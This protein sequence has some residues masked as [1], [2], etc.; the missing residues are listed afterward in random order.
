MCVMQW[1]YFHSKVRWIYFLKSFIENPSSQAIPFGNCSRYDTKAS[2]SV[3]GW[4]QM[5]YP[6]PS[7]HQFAPKSN[8]S[9]IVVLHWLFEGPKHPKKYGLWGLPSR[10]YSSLTW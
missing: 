4:T 6:Q 2:G 7:P 5:S 9:L 3:P 8:S 1:Y 10:L